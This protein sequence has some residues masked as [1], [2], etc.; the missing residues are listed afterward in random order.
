MPPDIHA[1]FADA[2]LMPDVPVPPDIVDPA[3]RVAPK[4]FAVYRNNVLVSLTEAMKATFPAVAALVGEAFFV[5]M[6]GQFVRKH[7]PKSPLLFDYGREFPEFLA[8]FP[9]LAGLPFLADVARLDHAWLD[10]YHAADATPFAPSALAGLPEERLLMTR[11]SPCPATHLVASVFPLV[12]IWQSAR[13]GTQPRFAEAPAPE[14]A[15]ITR[16]DIEIGVTALE[17]AGGRFFEALLGGQSLGPAAE[18]AFLVNPEFN[19]GA[20]LG[21]VLGLGGFAAVLPPT[22]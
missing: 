7:P 10:A 12:T 13:A 2:L 18:A 17:A 4:R 6:A 3:G 8:A 15:L 20:A 16:P 21:L 9:P 22:E 11:F 14:W 5:E 19:I 1:A